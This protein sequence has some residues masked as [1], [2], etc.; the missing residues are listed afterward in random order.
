MILEFPTDSTVD[1]EV[2]DYD[3]ITA[4]ELIGSVSLDI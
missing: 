1:I 2:W 3:P 4:D